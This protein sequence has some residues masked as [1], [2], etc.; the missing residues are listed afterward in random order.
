[1]R[2]EHPVCAPLIDRDLGQRATVAIAIVNGRGEVS[3][4]DTVWPATGADMDVGT[5]VRAVSADGP[6]VSMERV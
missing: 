3:L 4:G 1:M 6:V 5:H 2:P